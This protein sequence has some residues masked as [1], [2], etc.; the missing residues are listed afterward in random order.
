MAKVN[1]IGGIFLRC[2]DKAASIAWY[3][4]HLGLQI[5]NWGGAVLPI[6]P[7][8]TPS[9]QAPYSLVSFFA[10]EST[11]FDPSTGPVML[12]LRVDNLD[13]LVAQL[14]TDGVVLVGTPTHDDQFGKFAWIMDPD[15][16]KIE[17]WEQK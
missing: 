2:R 7:S 15:G 1:G 5:E 8:T 13:E 10:A 17:L 9:G 16:N 4:K 14:T 6:D 11:Y 3:S 12:N